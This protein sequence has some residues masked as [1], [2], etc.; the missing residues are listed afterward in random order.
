MIDNKT[1]RYIAVAALLLGIVGVTLG[2]AAF[3]STL[4][5]TSSAEVT[6][7]SSTFNV[8]F[9]SSNSSVQTNNITPTL[10][11]NV[12]G[13]SA[14]AAQ[15][16]NTGDPTISNLKATFTE[17]GQS[18]TYSFYAYNAGQ[19]IAY[20]NSVVFS[21]NKTCTARTGTTQSLVD[22]A[23]NGI[24]LSVK[25]G[26]E[27][28]TTTSISTITGHSLGING[29]EEVIVVISYEAGSGMADG[30]FDVTLPDVVLTYNSID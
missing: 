12:T 7:D 3:S 27:A 21:G 8:D 5:I 23:C 20:L 6:P 22:T 28:A 29:A 18:A 14:T 2:Y 17:P 26:S 13:F 24:N 1:Y 19:Y 16:D 25:V 10:S 15:I 30:S 11:A 9:S 4:R